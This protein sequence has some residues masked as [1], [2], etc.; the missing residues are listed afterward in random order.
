MA[1]PITRLASLLSCDV[2]SGSQGSDLFAVHNTSKIQAT[3]TR[4]RAATYPLLS[5][6]HTF[7]LY[8]VDDLFSAVTTRRDTTTIRAGSHFEDSA[9]RTLISLC[10]PA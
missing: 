2:T 8:D 6:T 4:L 1:A 9:G 5:R 7:S 10:C 3:T